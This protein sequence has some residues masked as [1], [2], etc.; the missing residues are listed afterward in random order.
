M[1]FVSEVCKKQ[2]I[3]FVLGGG[4]FGKCGEKKWKILNNPSLQ[5]YP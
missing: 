1:C 2:A 4:F 3:G 5:G